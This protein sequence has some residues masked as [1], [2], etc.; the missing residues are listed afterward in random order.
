MGFLSFFSSPEHDQQNFLEA[1]NSYNFAV[2][3]VLDR[4]ATTSG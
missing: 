1:N 3:E 2:E 4:R